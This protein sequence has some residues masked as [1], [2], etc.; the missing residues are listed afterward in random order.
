VAVVEGKVDA[1]PDACAD[2]ADGDAD[3]CHIRFGNANLRF[4]LSGCGKAETTHKRNGKALP[5]SYS[6]VEPRFR[7]VFLLP[8]GDG[9]KQAPRRVAKGMISYALQRNIGRSEMK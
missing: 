3:P 1:D 9:L 8:A 7:G 5:S 4:G 2:C 6:H